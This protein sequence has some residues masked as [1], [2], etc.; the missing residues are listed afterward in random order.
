MKSLISIFILSVVVSNTFG[1][2]YFKNYS[3]AIVISKA[4]YADVGWKSVADT[5][6]KKHSKKGAK[7]EVFEWSSTVTETKQKLKEFQPDYIG[8]IVKPV[9]ECNSKFLVTVSQ[10]CRSLDEDPYGDAI[11]GIITGY[12]S[13]DALRAVSESLVVKTVLAASANLL[14]EPPIQRFYQ[15]IGMTCDSY[16]KTDYLFP[17]KG[18]KIYTEEKRPEGETDRI[19]LV[20]KWLN[21]PEIN[22]EISGQGTIK[23]PV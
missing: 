17:G 21:A 2:S 22:I 13:S 11:Y 15:A 9:S 12:N 14:Y 19:K 6:L 8:F 4:S 5:L 16:T 7:V 10:M 3:Y 1:D 20:S 23:G 18:G